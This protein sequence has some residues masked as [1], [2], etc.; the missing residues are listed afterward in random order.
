MSYLKKK[1]K[2]AG[3]KGFEA[4]YICQSEKAVVEQ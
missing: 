2:G 4:V 3:G 1:I